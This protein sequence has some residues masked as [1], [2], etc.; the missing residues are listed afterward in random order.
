MGKIKI[1]NNGKLVYVDEEELR[2][3]KVKDFSDDLEWD[4]YLYRRSIE[5]YKRLRAE[6]GMGPEAYKLPIPGE[7]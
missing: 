2:S 5:S 4:R 7:T 6:M 3:M 1:I